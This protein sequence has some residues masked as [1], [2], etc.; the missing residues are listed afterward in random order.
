MQD[1]GNSMSER[2][3]WHERT[4]M[5]VGYEARRSRGFATAHCNPIRPAVGE[6]RPLRGGPV[7]PDSIA[8]VALG[9]IE[10]GVHGGRVRRGP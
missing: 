8:Y 6:T 4:L 2:S 1:H 5:T 9:L 7:Y 10:H 3:R